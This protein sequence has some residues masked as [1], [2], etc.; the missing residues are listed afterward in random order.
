VGIITQNS[1]NVKSISQGRYIRPKQLLGYYVRKPTPFFLT[2]LAQKKKY[3]LRKLFAS[4]I[5]TPSVEFR[6]CGRDQGLRALDLRKLLEK[7]DQNFYERL[8][9]WWRLQIKRPPLG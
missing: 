5:K 1:E 8:F 2:P 4:Q 9:V 3:L 6:A 7:F